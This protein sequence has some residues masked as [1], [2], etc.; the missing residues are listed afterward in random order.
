M[1][2]DVYPQIDLAACDGCGKCLPACQAGALAL[3]DEKAVLARPDL[4]EYD[5]A[6]EPACPT[7]AISLP[8]AVVLR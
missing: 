8:F 4:C 5:A 7:G 2:D 6:C 3:V 1:N